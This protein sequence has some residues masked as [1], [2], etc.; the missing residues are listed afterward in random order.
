MA[1]PQI[2]LGSRR[3]WGRH[4][5]ICPLWTHLAA[6]YS[7]LQQVKFLT[8][9]FSVFSNFLVILA[10]MANMWWQ[11]WQKPFW[12]TPV[13]FTG[14]LQL[15]LNRRA[16][17]MWGISRSINRPVSWNS[18]RGPTTEIRFV[19][20]KQITRTPL[21]FNQLLVLVW[22]PIVKVVKGCCARGWFAHDSCNFRQFM[23]LP[24][25]ASWSDNRFLNNLRTF[26]RRL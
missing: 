19:H 24:G 10:L 7:T 22:T 25:H 5:T 4:R 2:H 21:Y 17:L 3:I 23:A 13:K 20:K 16:K 18:A 8:T 15:F 9:V 6:R 12:N 14:H 11:P 26:S 1:R